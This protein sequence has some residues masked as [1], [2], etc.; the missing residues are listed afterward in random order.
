[1]EVPVQ[2]PVVRVVPAAAEAEGTLAVTEKRPAGAI[3]EAFFLWRQGEMLKKEEKFLPL[4]EVQG[5]LLVRLARLTLIA[6][7]GGELDPQDPKLEVALQDGWLKESRGTFVCLKIDGQLR[8]CIGNLT[9][10]IP[11]VDG[12]RDNALSA[13]LRDPRF[14]PL[15]LAELSRTCIEVSVLTEPRPLVYRDAT[16]LVSRL[17]PG[18]DGVIL[19]HGPASA[20]FLPQVWEQ[21]PEPEQ[22]LSHLCLKAGLAADYW[23]HSPLETMTYQVQYF[24]E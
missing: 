23:Q 6:R 19:R 7:L 13:A 5:Q 4:D 9:G 11:L 14:D 8:G 12:I 22:F 24:S 21:L 10:D 3:P 17:R 18:V 2:V 20:T 16:E 1:V 15:T